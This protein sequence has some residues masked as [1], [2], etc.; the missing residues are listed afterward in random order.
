VASR[1]NGT[2]WKNDKSR[3]PSMMRTGQTLR[4]G[5]V[6]ILRLSSAAFLSANTLSRTSTGNVSHRY[7]LSRQ[8][9]RRGPHFGNTICI[10]LSNDDQPCL[11]EGPD[12]GEG[13]GDDE[14]NFVKTN[15]CDGLTF[16]GATGS[17]IEMIAK[18]AKGLQYQIQFRDLTM[19]DVLQLE[20]ASFLRLA[21]ACLR[22]EKRMG[23]GGETPYLIG[24]FCP[25]KTFRLFFHCFASGGWTRSTSQFLISLQQFLVIL[26]EF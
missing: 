11:I 18:F 17:K 2:H 6:P 10:P 1:K 16:E 7:F 26:R 25:N 22:K 9:E 12:G 20:G 5:L 4:N 24:P 14:G 23:R 15:E 13:S 3:S 19:L 8:H 21:R